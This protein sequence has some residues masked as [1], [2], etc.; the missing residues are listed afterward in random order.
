GPRAAGPR[1]FG[2][3]PW[4]AIVSA[5]GSVTRCSTLSSA[6][7][8][9]L[10]VAPIFKESSAAT[11]PSTAPSPMTLSR[12]DEWNGTYATTDNR[13]ANYG[14]Y[15]FRDPHTPYVRAYW[16]PGIGIWQYDS[17]GVGAP[18]TAIER[19]DVNVVGRDVARGM[20]SRYCSPS[21]ALIGHGPPFSAQ[22]RRNAAWDPWTSRDDNTC[23]LCQAEF[24]ALTRAPYFSNVSLVPGIS[25]TGGASPRTCTLAGVVG[26]MACWY[27]NPTVGV[28]QGA[29][30][31]ATLAPDGGGNPTVTPAPL[32][33]PFYV[34]KRNGREE[35]HFLRIDTGYPIDIS[36]S[37]LLGVNERPRSNQPTSGVSWTS[38]SSLC[39]VTAGRGVCGASPPSTVVPAPVGSGLNATSAVVA[40][41][42]R[43]TS[44]DAN[45]DGRGDILWYA[46]GAAADSLWLGIG[47]GRFTSVALSIG[48]R[49]DQVVV[50][51]A[52]GDGRDDLLFNVRS[53]GTTY[54]RQSRGDG[55]F[56]SSQVRPGPRRTAV[57]GRFDPRG[58]DDLLWYGAGTVSDSSW[59]WNGH[60]FTTQPVTVDGSFQPTVG[61]Y[62]GNGFDDVLWYGPGSAVDRL[63]STRPDGSRASTAVTIGGTYRPQV[64]DF[65]GNGRDDIF[66]YAP[67]AT[68]D[69]TWL[70]SPTGGFAVQDLMVGGTAATVV[71][72]LEGDGRDDVVSHAPNTVTDLWIRWSPAGVAAPVALAPSIPHTP[73]V[74]AFSA[75]GADGIFWYAPGNPTDVV[76]WR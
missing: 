54:Y 31:W 42:Y 11:S 53:T 47:S 10:M 45:G 51:D 34:V 49:Y 63:W 40:G 55:T 37:R 15:A 32:A 2:T 67:G 26:T 18:F 27:V 13:S 66:W 56:A 14:L 73:V 12:Y 57:V 8:T 72:D 36:G 19:M 23:P 44:L 52:N 39:D 50:L 62:D 22:E 3:G 16:H 71:V 30:A 6:G 68:V 5:A 64:G 46:P 43:P 24:A 48:G 59:V 74:G 7:L 25:A 60:G 1:Y 58:G 29:T 69:P 70:A 76:W 17:A 9:A 4:N 75:E 33:E 38:T 21:A 61:D 35:R 41:T 28:I 65:D 20:A